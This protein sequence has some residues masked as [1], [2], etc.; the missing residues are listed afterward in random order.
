MNNTLLDFIHEILE[1]GQAIYSFNRG[2]LNP[3]NMK[4]EEMHNHKKTFNTKK[5]TVKDLRDFVQNNTTM[6][7]DNGNVIKGTANTKQVT[8]TILKEKR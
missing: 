3:K 5:F 2:I 1:E 8:L 4:F 6:I 7:K